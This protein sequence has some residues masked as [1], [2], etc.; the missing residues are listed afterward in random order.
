MI[1]VCK[2]SLIV[3]KIMSQWKKIQIT[4]WLIN[5]WIFFVQNIHIFVLILGW[6]MT[7]TWLVLWDSPRA[8]ANTQFWLHKLNKFFTFR[9]S[10][11]KSC[12]TSDSSLDRHMLSSRLKV[13]VK[14]SQLIGCSLVGQYTHSPSPV[15]DS[16]DMR[17]LMLNRM[18]VDL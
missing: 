14:V 1:I 15:C 6:N 3:T 13:T 2:M 8:A 12:T 5:N 11:M 7:Q 16:Q 10:K 18:C 17:C 4:I 9:A